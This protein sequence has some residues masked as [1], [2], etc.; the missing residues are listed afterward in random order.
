MT[1]NDNFDKIINN[2]NINSAKPT[3]QKQNTPK[4]DS[5]S[6]V[7]VLKET[8]AKAVDNKT[9]NDLK[10]RQYQTTPNDNLNNKVQELTF[11]KHARQ[12]LAQRNI[13]VAPE[14]VAKIRDAS[15]K[16]YD[17]NIKNALILTEDTA[18]IVNTASNVVVT[19]MN[20]S[21]MRDNIITNIDG[22]VI[23]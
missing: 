3:R 19:T 12:R 11:S 5:R 15:K 6:F 4:I 16:A 14:L 10:L 23:L 8:T 17:K 18:F 22:T 7:D 9:L 13:Y 1:I 2:L 20:N 21:E